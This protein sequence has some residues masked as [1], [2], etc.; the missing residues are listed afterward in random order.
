MQIASSKNRFAALSLDD[1]ESDLEILNDET[2]RE[3]PK[4]GKGRNGVNSNV[5]IP[6]GRKKART[7]ESM[8]DHMNSLNNQ[9]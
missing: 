5:S 6:T 8:N 1:E 4:G 7:Q 2:E 9:L 3:T